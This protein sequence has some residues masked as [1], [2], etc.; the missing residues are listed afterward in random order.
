MAITYL[1]SVSLSNWENWIISLAWLIQPISSLPLQISTVWVHAMSLQS[2]STLATQ[3]TVARQAPL[4]VGLSRQEYWHGLPCPPPRDLLDPGI[5]PASLM[6]PELTGRFFT[7]RATR[8]AQISTED[9]TNTQ[10]PYSTSFS[11]FHFG[12]MTTHG[13]ELYYTHFVEG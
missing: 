9:E 11:W 3:R 6:S 7:T 4:S 13:G 1:D 8:E 10:E 5:L 12:L 2:C